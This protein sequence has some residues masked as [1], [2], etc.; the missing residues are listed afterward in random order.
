MHRIGRVAGAAGLCLDGYAIATADD[1][2]RET[3]V[4]AGSAAGSTGGYAIGPVLGTSLAV[5]IGQAGPPAL[6]PEEFVTVPV[7][8]TVGGIIG[9]FF[10][11]FV[12][13]W[14]GGATYDATQN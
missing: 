13:S 2:A 6:L 8:S 4:V 11:D 5:G 9:G 14:F 10:G 12:G 7:L 1:R 3:A